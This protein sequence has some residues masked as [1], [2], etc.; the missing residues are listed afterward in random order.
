MVDSRNNLVIAKVAV[1]SPLRF[2]LDYLPPDGFESSRMV[3][4]M[5]VAI[6]LGKREVVGVVFDVVTGSAIDSSQLKKISLILDQQPLLSGELLKL[7]CWVSD[8]YHYPIGEVFSSFLPKLLRVSQQPKSDLSAPVITKKSCGATIV[9]NDDQE[10]A[11]D[12]IN[13]YAGVFKTFLLDGVTGSGKTEVYLRVIERVVADGKQALVLVPEINLTPQLVARFSERFSNGVVVFHSRLTPGERLAT[14]QLARCGVANIVIGTRSAIFTS[15]K[16]PGIIII[17]EEHDTSFKQQS[18]LRYSARDVAVVRGRLENVPVILG[19]ATPSMESIHNV[20]RRR[21]HLLSLS[22]RVGLAKQPTFHLVDMRNQQL[23]DGIA[24]SLL[25]KV[26][27]HLDSGNQVMIFL[28]R[29][30]FAP[31]IIC[32]HCGWTAG[33]KH[34]DAHLV[35]HHARNRLCCHHC[36]T[37]TRVPAKCPNCSEEKLLPLGIGTERIETLLRE[38]LPEVQIVRID[39]DTMRTKNS[40]KKIL[41]DIHSGKYQILIGT[42]MLAK[43]HHFPKVTMVAA[44]NIDQSLF[45][46]DF[47]SGEHLAQLIMQ[48]AGRAGRA[49]MSG[50]VYLQTHS[51]NHP[52]LLNLINR[53]YE[54]FVN[55]CLE[56]RQNASLPP[57][58]H[59]ALIQ[60]ESKSQNEA[61]DFLNAVIRD[62]SRKIHES[63]KIFGPVPSAMERKAGYFRLQLLLQNDNRHV[64]QQD[65]PK[66]LK[67]MGSAKIKSRIRWSL[68]V[69]PLELGG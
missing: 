38:I 43:G 45:N 20:K 62:V 26:R 6:P 46:F 64:L 53:G 36:G 15:L 14:W 24:A 28:N 55:N 16:N 7:V 17:D 52:L 49:E 25:Q 31:I 11:V 33:C 56:E 39:R 60:V 19:S 4:G 22:K 58:S 30:G 29:R 37:S 47:R 65:I 35:F 3:A 68:D 51:P 1:P 67:L 2:L 59:L 44:L 69:D 10:R 42:Q 61:T 63:T 12:T 8:Y 9:L 13:R 32:H 41:D 21:Y 34:C 50:E 40:F 54:G 48:V 23:K 27:Q 5:R 66:I 18:R 57:Y